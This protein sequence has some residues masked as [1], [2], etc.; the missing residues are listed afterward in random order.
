MYVK[1]ARRMVWNQGKVASFAKTAKVLE[2]VGK[3]RRTLNNHKNKKKKK[4]KK[5]RSAVD[6]WGKGQKWDS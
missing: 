1:R 2:M 3:R 6:A 4:K 5:R